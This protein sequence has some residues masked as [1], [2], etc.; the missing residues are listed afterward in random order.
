MSGHVKPR[1]CVPCAVCAKSPTP[2][3]YTCLIL[4]TS[5]RQISKR[6]IM[7]LAQA[8]CARLLVCA[9]LDLSSCNSHPA[10][11]HAFDTAVIISEPRPRHRLPQRISDPYIS[12]GILHNE[13]SFYQELVFTA[14]RPHLSL[15]LSYPAP[16]ILVVFQA[17]T[18]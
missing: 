7:L 2:A 4:Y 6:Q 9:L 11:L 15:F 10:S 3:Y 5:M 17:S 1:K 14:H 8:R 16:K 12:L 13:N 18:S